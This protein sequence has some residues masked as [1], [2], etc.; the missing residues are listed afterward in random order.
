MYI[1]KSFRIE[2]EDRIHDFIETYS[3]ATLFSQ[4]NGEPW[5]THLPLVLNKEES[6]LYC[7]F[8]LGNEQWKD[9]EGQPILAVFQGPHS[10]ISSSWYETTKAVPTWNYVAVHVYG[11]AEMINDGESISR[12]L[13]ELVQKYE[14]PDSSYKLEKVDPHYIEQLSKGIAPFKIKIERMEAKAK[15]SQN[16]SVERQELVIKQLE[17]SSDQDAQQIA[18]LMKANLEKKK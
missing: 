4:H 15:L 10:Y 11:K 9:V 6:A 17:K 1:P 14:Q 12:A 16:H 13:S 7:H 2:D 8:S 18:T 5:A 3:F